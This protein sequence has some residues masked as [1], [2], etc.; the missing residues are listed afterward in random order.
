VSV[1]KEPLLA[2]LRL[3]GAIARSKLS[4]ERAIQAVVEHACELTVASGAVLALVDGD[5]MVYRA[6]AGASADHVGR[7]VPRT[8]S[9]AGA[10][11][12]EGVDVK[13]ANAVCVPIVYREEVVGV[14]EVSS[15]EPGVLRPVDVTVVDVLADILERSLEHGR[16]YET[17]FF[18]TLHDSVTGL[19]NRRAFDAD[20]RDF[21]GRSYSV[22]LFDV[23]AKGD[24]ALRAF[25]DML[26]TYTRD[27]DR[28][29]RLGGDS[30]AVLMPET[31]PNVARTVAKRIA[32]AARLGKGMTRVRFTVAQSERSDLRSAA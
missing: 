7:R 28:T 12:D 14:I 23:H 15:S 24:D 19:L 32:A 26:A 4:P 3:E 21:V 29:F 11:V 6:A 25:A 16:L 13:S 2:I 18:D 20:L 31:S 30:L 27:D 17:M 8:G 9:L 1:R 22:V 5:T 10:C